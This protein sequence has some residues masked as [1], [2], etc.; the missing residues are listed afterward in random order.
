MVGTIGA[1]LDLARPVIDANLDGLTDD[2]YLWEPVAGCWS[3]RR[4]Q[5][6]R[7]PGCWGKGDWVVEHAPDGSVQP[8]LTTIGWRLM[9]AYDCTADYGDRAFGGEGHELDDVEVTPSAAV[10]V[11]MMI[12]ALDDLRASLD[13]A[14]TDDAALVAPDLLVPALHEAIHHCA[15]IGVLRAWWRAG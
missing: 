10:A 13:A 3:V 8:A 1:L 11:G 14:A 7:S 12:G 6:V 2:E 4:R 15:E 9:H 5:D